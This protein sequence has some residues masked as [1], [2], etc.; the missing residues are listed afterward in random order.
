MLVRYKPPFGYR[1]IAIGIFYSF[2]KVLEIAISQ[3]IFGL[4]EYFFLQND[5]IF[6]I[7]RSA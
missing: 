6:V 5:P 4:F 2:S 7:E 3:P 1:E